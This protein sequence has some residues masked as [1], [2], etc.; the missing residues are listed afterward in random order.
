MFFLLSKLADFFAQPLFWFFF[1]QI[2]VLLFAKPKSLKKWLWLNLAGFYLLA[3]DFISNAAMRA[4][5]MPPTPLTELLGN[6]DIC[7]VLGGFTILDQPPKDR[8]FLNQAADRMMHALLL[9]RR[10]RVGKLL[11]SGGSGMIEGSNES[12]AGNAARVLRLAQV[13][14][15]DLLLETKSKNTHENALFCKQ[16]L[17]S[18]GLGKARILVVTSAFHA[19]RAA[20]CFAKVGLPATFFST[21]LRSHPARITLSVLLLPNLEAL[22][23][24]DVLLHEWV[25]YAAYMLQGYI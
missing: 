19:P 22:S 1:L 12:E 15:A 18:L 11:V 3:N 17:D 20:R 6:F 10:G 8:V 21:D 4:W 24:W 2:G 13:P 25:G 16:M 23:R 9:Y 7:I 5:A 14:K